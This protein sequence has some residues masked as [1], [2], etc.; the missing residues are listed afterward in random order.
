MASK[1]NQ[2]V[3]P[4]YILL[5]VAGTLFT[6]T[7]C[8]YG[9]MAVRHLHAADRLRPGLARQATLTEPDIG[10]MQLMDEHGGR[11]MLV[12]LAIL[13]VTSLAAMGTDRYWASED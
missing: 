11:L 5:V 7:A 8:A 13:G 2:R 1:R 4:F 6:V 3:N 9:V 12:E 10:F